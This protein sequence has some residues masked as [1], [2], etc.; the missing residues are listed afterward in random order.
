[1]AVMVMD[2]PA[3]DLVITERAALVAWH[4]AQGEAMTTCDVAETV[5]LCRTAAYKL[6]TKLARVLPIVHLDG[7]W[8]VAFYEESFE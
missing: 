5:G 3:E 8:M 1:M 6:M 7:V 2:Y 4:L